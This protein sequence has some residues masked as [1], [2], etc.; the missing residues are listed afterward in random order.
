M[1]DLILREFNGVPI[2]QSDDGYFCLTDMAKACG[3]EFKEWN[4]LNSTSDLVCVLSRKVGIP[5]SQ[6]LQVKQGTRN[7]GTWGHRK[8]AIAFATW[9]SPE[10]F[11]VVIDWADDVMSKGGHISESAT[12]EQL[13]ALK[14]EIIEKENI[15]KALAGENKRVTRINKECSELDAKLAFIV[16]AI[17][18]GVCE[19][20]SQF[21]LS[22]MSSK[23]YKK[24]KVYFD[25]LHE[26]Q[27]VLEDI[28]PY[29]LLAHKSELTE[30]L[31][32]ENINRLFDTVALKKHDV[33]WD[34]NFKD[35]H[36]A[37]L[38]EN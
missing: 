33:T 13:E 24:Y 25:A 26:L 20:M 34:V 4:R 18:D 15:I 38:S 30:T 10:F 2:R 29:N 36:D 35:W 22:L 23:K 1:S 12:S 37:N 19:Q 27:E 8:V 21:D 7:A 9:C 5:T 32:N 28:M 11:S 31:T 16:Q 6:M 3:K 17:V 14:I